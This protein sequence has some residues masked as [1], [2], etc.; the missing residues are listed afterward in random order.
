MKP[1]S[2]KAI[3]DAYEGKENGV[4]LHPKVRAKM[5]INDIFSGF[6]KPKKKRKSK[7]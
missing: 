1:I 3:R 7:K 5:T 2:K 6:T 4:W